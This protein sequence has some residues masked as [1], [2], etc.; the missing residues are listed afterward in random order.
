MHLIPGP[1]CDLGSRHFATEEDLLNTVAE[2]FVKQDTKRYS[3][4]IHKLISRDNNC[5]DEQGDYVNKK[6]CEESNKRCFSKLYLF[7]T[8]F[9]NSVTLLLKYS[10][11]M[12]GVQKV[13]KQFFF[14][15]SD[16]PELVMYCSGVHL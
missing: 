10:L 12:K 9:V 7:F 3:A 5:H 13:T 1:K 2:F 4:G 16:K 15:S 11:Y 8:S 14:H 6:F